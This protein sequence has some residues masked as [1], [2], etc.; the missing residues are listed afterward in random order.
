MF[1]MAARP[2][3]IVWMRVRLGLLSLCPCITAPLGC[4]V[5][6]RTENKENEITSRWPAKTSSA[7]VAR[8]GHNATKHSVQETVTR[9]AEVPKIFT[10]LMGVECALVHSNS[11]GFPRNPQ[12]LWKQPKN[13]PEKGRSRMNSWFAQLLE[14]QN[15]IETMP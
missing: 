11:K 12:E 3:L 4:R 9:S 8:T 2:L 5:E 7:A 15:K 13:M 1:A 14:T 6:S 10:P